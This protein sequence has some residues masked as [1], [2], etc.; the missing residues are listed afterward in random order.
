MHACARWSTLRHAPG[1]IHCA[2]GRQHAG[3]GSTQ[4]TLA[5]PP[6]PLNERTSSSFHDGSALSTASMRASRSFTVLDCSEACDWWRPS[7]SCSTAVHAVID[8]AVPGHSPRNP[9]LHCPHRPQSRP[10]QVTC[11]AAMQSCKF[12]HLHHLTSNFRMSTTRTFAYVSCCARRP[13]RR[14]I[15]G[16]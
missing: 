14:A 5:L 6:G 16:R 15:S 3:G 11:M 9:R 7:S 2:C 8:A 12:H 1:P 4:H 13:S 10:R